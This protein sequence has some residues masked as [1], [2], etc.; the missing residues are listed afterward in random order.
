M[1]HLVALLSTSL[2]ASPPPPPPAANDPAII[3]VADAYVAAVLKNDT[4][5]VLSLYTA[6]MVRSRAVLRKQ[7]DA[8]QQKRHQSEQEQLAEAAII[9]RADLD[10]NRSTDL[11]QFGFD[12]SLDSVDRYIRRQDAIAAATPRANSPNLRRAA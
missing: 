10:A 7:L 12:F 2:L 5:A 6:R 11:T 8:L 4:A 9:R 1:F 3:A